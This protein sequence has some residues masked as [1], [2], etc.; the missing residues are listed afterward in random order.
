M[1]LGYRDSKTRGVA[2]LLFTVD[3]FLPGVT[4]SSPLVSASWKTPVV[5][6]IQQP[7]PCWYSVSLSSF[8]IWAIVH[9]PFIVGLIIF[10]M[11]Y[12]VV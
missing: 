9:I 10:T 6:A 2:S 4:L 12:Y 8:I 11:S 5:I 1:A 3:T 7:A